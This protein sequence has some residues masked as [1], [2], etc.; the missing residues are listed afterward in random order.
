M[1]T[2]FLK[3]VRRGIVFSVLGGLFFA[4]PS[5]IAIAKGYATDDQA[6]RPGMVAALSEAGTAEPKVERASL[7]HAAQ[8]IGVTTTPDSELVTVASAAQ[9]AYVQT[10]GEVDAFVS[11][12]NGEVTQGDTLSISPLKGILM[13]TGADRVRVV[14]VA[15]E[16]FAGKPTETMSVQ[17]GNGTRE[18]RVAKIRVN[19]DYK[20]STDQAIEVDSSLER[21]GRAL[22]GRDVGEI[23]V[24]AALVIF[25]IVLVAEGGIIYGAIS[26]AI[27]ALGRNPMARKIIQKEVFKVV[28]VAFGV[29][30][31]GLGAIYL[32]L[33]I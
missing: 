23:R 14:G 11:D 13:K 8:I 17:D 1:Q 31:I 28:G 12:L 2:V 22:T 3:T 29:L 30:L 4:V 25:L 5:V 20:A 16:N 21:L 10:T 33:W 7:D 18:I 9:Q 27:T 26:S 19:L 32:I 24:I 6:L 15:L